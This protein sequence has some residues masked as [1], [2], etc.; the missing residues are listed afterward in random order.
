MRVNLLYTLAS[1]GNLREFR[2]FVIDNDINSTRWRRLRDFFSALSHCIIFSPDVF[3]QFVYWDPG[4]WYRLYYMGLI[5][6]YIFPYSNVVSSIIQYIIIETTVLTT[7]LGLRFTFNGG[8]FTYTQ[9]VASAVAEKETLHHTLV[10]RNKEAQSKYPGCSHCLTPVIW[11]Q[12]Y[13][14]CIVHTYRRSIIILT[15]HA[16][17]KKKTPTTPQTHNNIN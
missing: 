9:T 6:H 4:E 7:A 2:T 13:I 16:P 14:H 10:E 1:I 15:I 12:Y 11:K 3:S 17:P 5:L 8:G